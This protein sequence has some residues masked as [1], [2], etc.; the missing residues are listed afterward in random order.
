MIALTL[1]EIAEITGGVLH[2]GADPEAIVSSFVEFD[3]RKITAGG[4]F[5]ALPGARVDGHDY[6]NTAMA[7]GAVAVL[8]AR[9]VGV[10]AIV[11]TPNGRGDSTS[12]VYAHDED[13]SA[14]AVVDALSALAHAVVT[15]LVHDSGLT[16]VGITGSAGKTST[17]D[18][19]ASV[20][21][22]AGDTVAPP[23]SFNNEVGLPY[24]AL[25][26][27]SD[28]RFLV[29]E[30]SARGIGHIAHLAEITPPRIGAVLNVGSAHLGEF[31]SRD[32]IARA[33]GELVEAL[34]AGNEGGVAV[35]NLDDPF[36]AA[37]S[38][39][40][41]ARVLTY[42]AT[43]PPSSGADLWASN[44][45]LDDVARAS[46]TLNSRSDSAQVTLQVFGE[47][48][49]SNSLAA[50]AIGLEAGLS[51]QQVAEGLQNHKSASAHRMD[52]R[53]GVDGVTVINDSYNANPDSMRAGIAALAYTVSARPHARAIAVL[54]EMNELGPDA[55]GSHRALGEELDRYRVGYLVAVGDSPNTR[56]MAEEARA[57]G[58]NTE[59]AAD[60]DEA[61][62]LVESVL[63]TCPAEYNANGNP[64][65][66]VLVKA[67]NSLG[68]WRVAEGLLTSRYHH[69]EKTKG[70]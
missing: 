42:S 54:G 2:D 18:F 10:P 30:M 23:G 46:F 45:V 29:A 66:V 27:D 35:L 43:T 34:P 19:V 64:G 67:S 68:L 13:G 28:T 62:S 65:D 60:V 53:T 4:L 31:G 59:I 36:V 56:A 38:S 39:R 5:L 70:I 48:Q 37:M 51:L 14:K 41:R 44:V 55:A 69:E 57:R 33:K 40:T 52:V 20:L 8:A 58:I 22:Q 26:C 1:A 63:R 7:A 24:T 9:P 6:A 16:V 25:R 49:V 32:N 50:A 3:S 21:R 12:E 15:K 61:V 17:K 11:V 47:H